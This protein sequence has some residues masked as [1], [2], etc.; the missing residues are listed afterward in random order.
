MEMV[1][2]VDFN[3]SFVSVMMDVDAQPSAI[4]G[5]LGGLDVLKNFVN[6]E[7]EED[8]EG[9]GEEGKALQKEEEE[10]DE[11]VEASVQREFEVPSNQ[12]E[13]G[14][15]TVVA[16]S[17]SMETNKGKEAGQEQEVGEDDGNQGEL[18]SSKGGGLSTDA[19]WKDDDGFE[20]V[21]IG[22]GG[23]KKGT[24]DGQVGI[25]QKDKEEKVM[26]SQ[27]EQNRAVGS[28]KESTVTESKK[29]KKKKKKN[30]NNSTVTT[31]QEKLPVAVAAKEQDKKYPEKDKT[32]SE[33]EKK[34]QV[35]ESIIKER[36]S[37]LERKAEEVAEAKRVTDAV[38]KKNE[39][40]AMTQ[41]SIS[42]LDLENMR[43]YGF[44]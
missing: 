10:R 39:E 12:E 34:I 24:V 3:V 28:V 37:Q 9:T 36:E 14:T 22:A 6:L 27:V 15:A 20:D 44:C 41:A 40:L 21:D 1:R 11:M 2:L 43:R 5:W 29:K 17:R 33:M 35:L 23:E 18:E 4:A 31:E 26:P 25:H 8:E 30:S 19:G 16:G 32:Y 42:E 38:V 13:V 7:D